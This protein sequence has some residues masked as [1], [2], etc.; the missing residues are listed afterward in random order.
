MIIAFYGTDGGNAATTSNLLATALMSYFH[1]QKKVLMASLCNGLNGLE[2]AFDDG[3][4][5]F[6][7]GEEAEYFYREGM[8]Y[9]LKEAAYGNIHSGIM[10]RGARELFV[11]RVYYLSSANG[12]GWKRIW[13]GFEEHGEELLDAMEDFA[14]LVFLDC[15]LGKGEFFRNILRRADVVV[16]NL[17][18]SQRVIQQFFSTFP[19]FFE[20]TVYLIGRYDKYFPCD[21]GK[22]MN[23]CRI[24]RE[25]LGVIP[26]NSGFQDAFQ[27]GRCARFI[28]KNAFGGFY[29]KNRVFSRELK[30]STEM[31]LRKAELLV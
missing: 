10:E 14:E 28:Q 12:T 31:I 16:V 19:K 27:N 4:A 24:P 3:R 26:Y 13:K 6:R 15:G 20:K 1:Y 22:I 30:A 25:H 29:E 17:I 18:Q 8:D 23:E 7:I 2:T 11:Q 9:V 5:S 21:I